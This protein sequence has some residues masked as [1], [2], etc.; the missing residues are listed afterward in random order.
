M[1]LALSLLGGIWGVLY[2]YSSHHIA[3]VDG[4]WVTIM[5]FFGTV[6]GGPL[7]GWWSD[8][9]GLRRA[10]MITGAVVSLVLILVMMLM[11]NLSMPA[12]LVL[13]F[14]IG[15]STSTQI[16]AYP[17][18]AENSIPFITAMSVSVVNIT[19]MGGQAIFQPFFGELM[20][21]HAKLFHH[22]RGIYMA[23]DFHWAMLIL[24]VAFVFAFIAAFCL[25]ETHCRPREQPNLK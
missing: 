10:P 20:D 25:R 13:F 19:T 7:V 9:V 8:R 16:I 4:S 14:A 3:K 15:F 6:V 12:L 1:N 5:L 17:T 2:L 11:P 22:P 21:L 24:P 23:N 18:V